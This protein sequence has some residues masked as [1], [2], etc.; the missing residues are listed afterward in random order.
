[1]QTNGN[2]PLTGS[3]DDVAV[4]ASALPGT[5]VVRHYFSGVNGHGDAAIR[6]MTGRLPNRGL[7]EGCGLVAIDDGCARG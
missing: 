4:Y 1:V 2:Y 7:F 5:T 3:I 6:T